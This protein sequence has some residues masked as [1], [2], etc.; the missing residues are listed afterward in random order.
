M[1]NT[2]DIPYSKF[3]ES[4]VSGTA[5]QV[6]S[7]EPINK[8]VFQH[9]SSQS[10]KQSDAVASYHEAEDDS[11]EEEVFNLEM[12]PSTINNINQ[13]LV[14]FTSYMLE[15]YDVQAQQQASLPIL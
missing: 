6:S 12:I 13:N 1:H 2:S 8:F 9:P 10:K 7:Y 11:D 14:R 4:A 15:S 5:T 3:I